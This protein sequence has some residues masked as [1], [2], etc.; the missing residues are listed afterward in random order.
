MWYKVNRKYEN[1]YIRYVRAE[2]SR[3]PMLY[4]LDLSDGPICSVKISY[5]HWGAPIWCLAP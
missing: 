1:I 3:D 2:A 5:V 4:I